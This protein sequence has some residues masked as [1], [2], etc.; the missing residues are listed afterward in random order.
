[1]IS[2]L[3]GAVA[4]SCAIIAPCM[5]SRT[6]T[7]RFQIAGSAAFVA[8]FLSIEAPA[9]AFICSVS[10]LQSCFTYTIPDRYIVVRLYGATLIVIMA[11][12][13]ATWHGGVSVLALVGGAI[14]T[15]ARMQDSVQRM[16]VTFL[17]ASPFWVLHDLLSGAS[18][19]I[20]CDAVAIACNIF[21]IALSLRRL[22]SSEKSG[23][24]FV[25]PFWM[26]IEALQG[27]SRRQ[28]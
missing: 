20:I 12:C 14:G 7:L 25:N 23:A 15:L 2:W 10:L 9:A 18:F 8:Y 24:L 17:L 6:S 21:G 16:K 22:P 3:W 13:T 28:R 5:Q 1:M 27:L 19:A 4:L 11:T 26:Q